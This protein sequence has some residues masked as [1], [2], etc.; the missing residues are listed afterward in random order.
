[1]TSRFPVLETVLAG[2]A[3]G[4]LG[5]LWFLPPTPYLAPTLAPYALGLSAAWTLG[6]LWRLD[7]CLA[8]RRRWTQNTVRVLAPE[9]L[10]RGKGLLL[11]YGFRW[12]APHTQMLE[13]AVSQ[14]GSLPVDPESQG[15]YAAL[16]AVG[17]GEEVEVRLPWSELAGQVG[18]LGTTRCHAPGTLILMADGTTKPVEQIRLGEHVMGPDS[19]PRTILELHHGVTA[20]ARVHP[21]RG[22]AFDVTMDHLLPIQGNSRAQAQRGL[23]RLVTPRTWVAR[24]SYAQTCYS[25]CRTGVTF[26]A[27]EPLPIPPY[28]LGV[29]LG[30]GSFESGSPRI[31]NPD[32]EVRDEM[33][34]LLAQIGM[35]T[36]T[37]IVNP[38]RCPVY[39]ISSTAAGHAVRHG[40]N[41][42]S[43]TLQYL[44]LTEAR[45]GTKFIPHAYKVA[46]QE[47]RL[48]LLAGLLDTD[49][50]LE[51]AG[52]RGGNCY[53]YVSKSSRLVDDIAFVVRSLGL[54]ATIRP[55]IKSWQNGTGLYYRMSI[56]GDTR[57]IPCQIPRKQ[58]LPRKHSSD[59]LRT[60]FAIEALS[61]GPYYGF[62]CDG[63]H[64]YLT[65]D[66]TVH[67]NSGKTTELELLLVQL[68]GEAN[69]R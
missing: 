19:M 41:L 5:T 46:S 67:H 9:A 12:Q 53:E 58:A 2:V 50:Y 4:S 7:R 25:L 26:P 69:G 45:S 13:T 22:E 3:A 44:G 35:Y 61:D 17:Y 33:T 14:D 11:G 63:D 16:Q 62:A 38:L 18:L 6:C 55:A 10:P 49:G 24:T 21:R 43:R 65:A 1:M 27:S 68:I 66:F 40:S 34:R 51:K 20:M 8:A 56:Y 15:G 42:V 36:R 54:A 48:A 52:T 39:G 32:A 60:T 31:S 47:D 23:Y 64:Q 59:V 57:R 37:R 30:D 29:W 28:V